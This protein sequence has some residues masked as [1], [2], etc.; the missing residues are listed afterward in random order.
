MSANVLLD[1]NFMAEV[2]EIGFSKTGPYLD[3]THVTTTV[4]GSFGYLDP[5]YLTRQQL[6]EK[7]VVYSLCL[8]NKVG[9][10]S[11]DGRDQ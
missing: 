8:C 10:E 5:E 9:E 2:A 11:K 4:K 7:S 1:E 3:Q 6:T